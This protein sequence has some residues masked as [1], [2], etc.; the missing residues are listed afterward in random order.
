MNAF[1]HK[2]INFEVIISDNNSEDETW[3]LL[4]ELKKEYQEVKIIKQETLLN[5]SDHWDTVIKKHSVGE[6]VLLLSD[7]DILNDKNYLRDACKI[8]DK[9]DE[10]SVVFARYQEVDSNDN[11]I[12]EY[13]TV[14]PSIV[15]G[16]DMLKK[17]N[18]GKD[19]FIPFLTG[20]FRRSHYVRVGGFKSM[21]PS[22]DLYLWLKLTAVGNFSFINRSVGKYMIHEASLSKNPDPMQQILDIKMLDLVENFFVKINQFNKF[23]KK[24]L[25]RIKRFILRRYHS[26]IIKNIFLNKNLSLYGLK[27]YTYLILF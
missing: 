3:N 7:D 8:L 27:M 25:L 9:N 5:L 2:E 16:K 23:E 4:K 11:I 14:W 26:Q 22:A 18:S 24:H 12:G 17:Y 6:Y 1:I 10:V 21:A 20:V 15:S 13:N 19:L